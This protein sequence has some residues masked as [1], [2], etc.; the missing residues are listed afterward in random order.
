MRPQ[1]AIHGQHSCTRSSRLASRKR[2]DNLL[3]RIERLGPGAVLNFPALHRAI[4]TAVD[5]RRA[6][7]RIAAR[8]SRDLLEH[9]A[10]GLLSAL[11]LL[12]DLQQPRVVA[13]VVLAERCKK[14]HLIFVGNKALTFECCCGTYYVT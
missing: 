12:R 11:S 10:K 2:I 5:V 8:R 9:P 14:V 4:R 6:L 1:T 3:W 7:L 13:P